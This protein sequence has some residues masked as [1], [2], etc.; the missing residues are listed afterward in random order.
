MHLL[1]FVGALWRC[2]R[3]ATPGDG[4]RLER[5]VRELMVTRGLRSE[6]VPGG[7]SLLGIG[8][9]SGLWHQ[10]DLEAHL[11]DAVLVGELKA[12]T[13]R[14][15]KNELLRFVAATDDLYVGSSRRAARTPIWRAIAGTFTSTPAER[16]FAAIHGVLVVEPSTIPSLLLAAPALALPDELDPLADPERVAVAGLARPMQTLFSSSPRGASRTHIRDA[17]TYRFGIR[18]QAEWSTRVFA[19][20]G[21]EPDE[22]DGAAA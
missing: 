3:A 16:S 9:A 14:L 19:S 11:D 1:P 7:Y 22:K 6:Q 5:D 21:P 8:S 4:R 2:V 13:G 10:L 18:S 15:P 12:H 17:A 20:R